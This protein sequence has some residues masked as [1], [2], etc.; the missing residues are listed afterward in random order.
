MS[1]IR[2]VRLVRPGPGPIGT[3]R[4]GT[5]DLRWSDGE[6]PVITAIEPEL[7]RLPGEPVTEAAGRWAI[8][9][10]WD[11]HV[12]LGQWALARTRL[13]LTGSAGPEEVVARVVRHLATRPDDGSD[14]DPP[15]P[16]LG[17]GYRSGPWARQPTVAELDAV[18]GDR[19]VA[20]T[21]GD[22]H[23]GWLNTAA[24]RLLGLPGR[25]T[26]LEENEWFAVIPQLQA[27]TV[28][29]A[30]VLRAYR[31]AVADA[32]AHGVVGVTD[33]EFAANVAEWPARM[34][35]GVDRLRIRAAS[36]PDALE[37]VISRGLR[38]GDP[39]DPALPLLRTGP[40]KII[41]DGSLNTR[42]AYCCEPYPGVPLPA[43]RGT[44]NVGPEEL[45]RLLAR[46]D[47]HGIEAAV[48]AIGDAAVADALDAFAATGARGSVEHA[49]LMRRADHARMAA[50]PVR[51]SVQPAHLLDDRDVTAQLWPDRGD[52]CF[53][54]R[55]L[56]DA[57]VPLAL[58]SD[59]PVS[60]L[61]P[62]LAMA[63]AVHRSADERPP[64]NPDEAITAAE[65]L[66]A[67]TDGH[68]M[69]TVGM[70]ADLVL[71]DHDPLPRV[72]GTAEAGAALR[73]VRVAATMVAGRFTHLAL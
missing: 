19:P 67:S 4:A 3:D 52:R 58:G 41:S 10:L 27:L 1:L 59:A 55:S 11:A 35:A 63:A 50:L 25:D 72:D 37:D 61:D 71:L 39:V 54:L 62:W 48:H 68:P 20:L 44:Q 24:L 65:A 45:Q 47:A 21:S 34:A 46:A 69:I 9:G 2:G 66:I 57:G 22:A 12:H 42:T 28:S 33:F 49:Q 30:T 70:P 60:P 23:N 26:P 53:P 40:L 14:A 32:A 51:A 18:V 17:Q 6:Q 43:P 38:T 5:V 7:E 36:Y 8:P 29:P 31:E 64:W 13:D 73:A 16:L 15:T 56:L